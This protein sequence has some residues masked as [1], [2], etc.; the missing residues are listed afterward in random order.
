MRTLALQSGDLVV[1]QSGHKT[2]TG[3]AKIRQDLALAMGEPYGTDRFHPTWGSVLPDYV[4][5]PI[6]AD[7]EMAVRS[8]AAR[9]INE[10]IQIQTTEILQDVLNARRTRY[11]TAD[12]VQQV[13]DISAD[14]YIDQIRLRVQMTTLSGQE[15][16]LSRTV[17]EG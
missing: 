9:V 10:Y 16:A 6:V 12:V 15:L 3:T 8:E 17:T 13:D 5:H 14:I 4:G 11:D 2:I 7:T 1:G